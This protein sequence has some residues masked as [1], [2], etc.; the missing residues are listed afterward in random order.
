MDGSTLND[1]QKLTQIALRQGDLRSALEQFLIELRKNFVFDNVAIY[2][3][4]EAHMSLE[5]EY[6]RAIGRAKT[7]EA[8]AAWGETFASQVVKKGSLLL[9]DPSP[10]AKADDRLQQAYLLGLPLLMDQQ[11][12]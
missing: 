11:I 6:A 10:G 3:V 1:L 12:N 7:A 4:D 2:L 9:L 5:V 8:D